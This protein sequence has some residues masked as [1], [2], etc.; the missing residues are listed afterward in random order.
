MAWSR[1][2]FPRC[3]ARI[4]LELRSIPTKTNARNTSYSLPYLDDKEVGLSASRPKP[5]NSL[6]SGK[7]MSDKYRITCSGLT[8]DKKT[9]H[10]SFS[11]GMEP[12]DWQDLQVEIG[13]RVDEGYVVWQ[14]DL[15]CLTHIDSPFIGSIVILN[16]AIRHMSCNMEV[17]L[18]KDSPF[19]RIFSL[20]ELDQI[21]NVYPM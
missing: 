20:L 14:L 11:P 3:H 12:Q 10:V 7:N 15:D 21:I 4:S 6:R 2:C 17:I 8:G 13:Q 18:R 16:A 19:T 1:V 9:G 5:G